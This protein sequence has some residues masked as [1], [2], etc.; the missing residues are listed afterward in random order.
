MPSIG[1]GTK[2][3]RTLLAGEA[4]GVC[5]GVGEGA[6][7]CSG[8]TEGNG[9][10]SLGGEGMAVDDSCA[11]AIRTKAIEMTPATNVTMRDLNIVAPVHVWKNV[12]PRFAI[13]EEFFIH[14]VGGKL[15]VETVETSKVIDSTLG[16][17]FARSPVFH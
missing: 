10:S 12:V 15:I 7:E 4:E 8:E 11:A 16:R 2:L 1:G 17:V 14:D 3:T 9:D 5:S 13:T 6:V